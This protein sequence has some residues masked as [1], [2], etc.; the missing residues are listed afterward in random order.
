M[1]TSEG[2]FQIL[3]PARSHLRRD[4][5][6]ENAIL[7]SEIPRKRFNFDEDDMPFLD[8]LVPSSDG[9][10]HCPE[11]GCT[12]KTLFYRRNQLKKHLKKHLRPFHCPVNCGHRTWG[13]TEMGRHVRAHHKRWAKEYLGLV[14]QPICQKCGEE[15][16]RTDNLKKHMRNICLNKGWA[17]L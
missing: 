12:P 17:I 2:H 15:F 16:T 9:L 11:P 14:V 6:R 4:N 7:S 1:G 5:V 3:S 10:F 8:Y 13:P